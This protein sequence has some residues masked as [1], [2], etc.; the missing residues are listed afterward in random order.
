MVNI[1]TKR[2]YTKGTFGPLWVLKHQ[3]AGRCLHPT[4]GECLVSCVGPS[5][6]TCGSLELGMCTH[7]VSHTWYKFIFPLV[8]GALSDPVS[9]II[10]YTPPTAAAPGAE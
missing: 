4:D 5:S 1:A 9:Y 8:P 6:H 7:A 10:G 3:N 2:N